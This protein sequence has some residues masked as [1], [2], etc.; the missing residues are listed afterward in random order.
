MFAANRY[1]QGARALR[2]LA[3]A[4]QIGSPEEALKSFGPFPS[5]QLRNAQREFKAACEAV[6]RV[7]EAQAEAQRL[8]DEWRQGAWGGHAGEVEGCRKGRTF[9]SAC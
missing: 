2:S 8:R 5:P 9:E 6:R 1:D 7:A 3:A 4:G